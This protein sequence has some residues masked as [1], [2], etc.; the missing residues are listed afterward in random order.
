MARLESKPLWLVSSVAL[1]VI[2]DR[3]EQGERRRPGIGSGLFGLDISRWPSTKANPL[4]LVF[5]FRIGWSV[6][7]PN[8]N[9]SSGAPQH[10]NFAD[11]VFAFHDHDD[12]GHRM[13]A[14]IAKTNGL[15]PNDL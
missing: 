12:I 5:F 9:L 13:L 15:T 8:G 14:R 1:R 11:F 10:P 6:N 7:S 2:A 4:L 3:L